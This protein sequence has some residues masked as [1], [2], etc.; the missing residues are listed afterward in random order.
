[1]N[2]VKFDFSGGRYVVTGASSGIGRQIA[3][4]LA[5]AG[6][7]VLA[8]GRNVERLEEVKSHQPD[9]IVTASLDVCDPVALENAIKNFVVERGKLNGGVHAAGISALTTLKNFDRDT[10]EKIM[11]TSFWAAV[12][13]VNLV[14]KSKYGVN[15]TSTVLFSSTSALA[16]PRGMFAYSASKAAVDS[17]IKTLSKEIS[18]KKHR[19]NSVLPNW[20]D[21]S[22]TQSSAE[23]TDRANNNDRRLLGMG[24]PSDV[25]APVLFLLSDGA[26]WITGTNVVVDG[27]YLA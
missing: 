14:T 22:M 19:L 15:G 24:Q 11:Q 5:D 3:L 9:R 21:T 23:W 27:G 16:N 10:A 13:F 7:E 4:D 8:I 25:S 26:R 2:N 1:M 17:L 18:I 12:D 6:A 20:V